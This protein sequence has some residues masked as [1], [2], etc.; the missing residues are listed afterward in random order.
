MPF[1]TLA[2][3]AARAVT[4]YALKQGAAEDVSGAGE[5]LGEVIALT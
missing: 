1:A 2:F 5:G 4:D 3:G